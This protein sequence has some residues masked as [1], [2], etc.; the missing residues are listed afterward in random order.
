[1]AKARSP[2]RDKVRRAW[3]ESGGTMT[4]KQLAEEFS[5]RAEQVRKW[6]SLDNW[7][8]D[9]DAQ[10]PKRK[11]GGQPGNK[12]CRGRGRAVGNKKCRNARGIFHGPPMR[13]TAGT[14][15]VYRGNHAGHRNKYACRT[16][17]TDCKGSRPAK[18]DCRAGTWRPAALY[19][20]R[21]VEMRA[22]KGTKRLEQQREKL[23]ALQREEDSLIWDMDGS[24]GKKPTRQ[25]ERSWKPC[26]VRLPP[27]RTPRATKERALE[28]EGYGDNADCHKG[29][30]I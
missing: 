26:N 7:Q 4:A 17:N 23:E 22:P 24:D 28:R 2:E 19:I 13:S 14:A 29:K 11:R 9:L 16:A 20:D 1:M 5:V 18:Q 15:R 27:C 6:K 10:K 8:A 21:V 30:R 12:K 3:L 25:Q